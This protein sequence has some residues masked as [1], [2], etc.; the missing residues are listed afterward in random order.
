LEPYVK[1]EPIPEKNDGGVKIAVAKNFDEVVQ[2]DKDILIEF[3][4]P[5]CGHC[6]K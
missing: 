1:S 6:K 5:W 2:K 4:A 3:Y